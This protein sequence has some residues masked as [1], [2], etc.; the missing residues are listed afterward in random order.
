MHLT[1]F[2]IKI[3]LIS[4]RGTLSE[5]KM[6]YLLQIGSEGNS[7]VCG[8]GCV[9]YHHGFYKESSTIYRFL[10]I[11]IYYFIC[12]INFSLLTCDS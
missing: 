7:F 2:P 3:M 12:T 1:F 6:T 10:Q 5:Y 8:G 11:L 4:P 9:H